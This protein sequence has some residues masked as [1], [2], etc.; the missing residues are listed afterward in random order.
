MVFLK[1]IALG[2]VSRAAK[3]YW[4]RKT[5]VARTVYLAVALVCIT[6]FALSLASSLTPNTSIAALLSTESAD[7]ENAVYKAS[8][9]RPWNDN[10]WRAY[11]PLLHRLTNLAASFS[12]N[13]GVPDVALSPSLK[14]QA[15]HHFY[16][17]MVSGLSTIVIGWILAS[18][19]SS[20][21]ATR[22]IISSLIAGA[23][24]K[25]PYWQQE[26]FLVHPDT[27]LASIAAGMAFCIFQGH[28]QIKLNKFLLPVGG[29][30]GIGMATKMTFLFFMPV[31]FA[32][33]IQRNLFKFVNRLIFVLAVGLF[34]YL[35]VG[36]PQS[37]MV[38]G[39]VK[40]LLYQREFT[41]AANLESIFRWL[42]IILN[43]L[44]IIIPVILLSIMLGIDS[45]PKKG[46]QLIF[47]REPRLL[48]VVLAFL[49]AGMLILTVNFIPSF[50]NAT[51][52][53]AISFVAF[54][55]VP[56]T[57]L[58]MNLSR[59][60]ISN[61]PGS[62]NRVR[63]IVSPVLLIGL[64]Y[65]NGTGIPDFLNERAKQNAASRQEQSELIT[66]SSQL[67]E[68][69][70]VAFI[71]PYFPNLKFKV[72]YGLSYKTMMRFRNEGVTSV[73][74]AFLLIDWNW[75]SRFLEPK[76]TK[77]DL[78]GD[79]QKEWDSSKKLYT[80]LFKTGKVD[81]LGNFRLLFKFKTSEI[82]ASQE[83]IQKYNQAQT[84]V[85]N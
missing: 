2:P 17:S 15:R 44:A 56:I 6:S 41:A 63:K 83:L 22:L 32:A 12:P 55:L 23:L 42:A 3:F 62:T 24:F 8:I 61:L 36:F 29:L 35:L 58:L 16:L 60:L 46:R 84:G 66:I 11:G 75:Y 50:V 70:G 33:F 51:G 9:T 68:L 72:Q 57:I 34:T 20:C 47:H 43:D 79:G 77:Y 48:F 5:N 54:S 45:G 49:P 14:N 78:A 31:I 80:S 25:T 19:I 37:L 10:G 7:L 65:F 64:A 27:L 13:V 69:G 82:W 26:L 39:V 81:H 73:P 52:H 28:I 67:S 18:I 4:R 74:N 40:F 85:S 59:L 21:L 38:P 53:Y 76:P 71:S 1:K 30:L